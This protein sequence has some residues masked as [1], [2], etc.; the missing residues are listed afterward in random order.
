MTNDTCPT[1]RFD[2]FIAGDLVDAKRICRH[3]CM[4]VGFCVTV[5]PVDYVYT[6]GLESGVKVG[7]INYPRFPSTQDEL[8]RKTAQLADMLMTNLCQHSYSIV[9]PN[10]TAWVSRRD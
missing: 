1:I 4:E 2:I 8:Y 10:E 5:E 3:Y 9:G 7:V 6:G